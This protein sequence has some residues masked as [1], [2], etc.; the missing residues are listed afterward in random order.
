[1]RGGGE[2]VLR[3]TTTH[4]H[5]CQWTGPPYRP[6]MLYIKDSEKMRK[7]NKSLYFRCTEDQRIWVNEYVQAQGMTFQEWL[8]TVL[9]SVGMPPSDSEQN[10]NP[11]GF[12]QMTVFDIMD[13][14]ENQ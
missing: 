5:R 6:K 3:A 13:K 7:L 12:E 2:R 11:D 8:A 14:K 10:P 9:E 4:P 1:M